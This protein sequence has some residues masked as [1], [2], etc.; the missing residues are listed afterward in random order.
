MCKLGVEG[1]LIAAVMSMY[2]G[3]KTVVRTVHGN[4]ECFE[5]KVGMHQGSA[6]S[7]LL[8][9]TVM[10]AISA[11]TIFYRKIEIEFFPKIEARIEWRSCLIKPSI[12][13]HGA[14]KD[15]QD[16]R[17]PSDKTEH[18]LTA[19]VG[20]RMWHGLT[21]ISVAVGRSERVATHV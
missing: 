2:T 12:L 1:C 18:T 13:V 11:V 21:I 5:V 17:R 8:F 16:Q 3:A 10:E 7:P 4:S 20:R 19:T 6:L 14:S 9:V 15:R